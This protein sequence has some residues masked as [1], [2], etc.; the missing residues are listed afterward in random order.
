MWTKESITRL[1]DNSDRAVER[2]ILALYRRQTLDEQNSG[3]TTH[4]NGVG[5]SGAHAEVGTYYA[6]WILSG[7]QLTGRHLDR[8]RKMTK[9]YVAQLLDEAQQKVSVAA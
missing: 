3:N 1:L 9:H 4:R 8:A 2:A 6:K 7:R 5:F